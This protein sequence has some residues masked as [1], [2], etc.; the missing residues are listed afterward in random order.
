MSPI[1]KLTVSG[2]R[3][4]L[5]PLELSFRKGG[6]R[7]SIVLYGRNGTGKSSITDAWEWLHASRIQRLAR[8]GAGPTSYPHW[9]AKDDETY[10]EV[11]LSDSDLDVVGLSFDHERPTKPEITGS[12]E[13]FR[14]NAPH[15]CHI[16]FG[17][18]TA[19]VYLTKSERYD[20]LARL[21][22]FTPQVELQKALRRTLRKVEERLTS[23]KE[24]AERLERALADLFGLSE[25]REVHLLEKINRIFSRHNIEKVNDLSEAQA[26]L[27]ALRQKVEVD[28]RARELADLKKLKKAS[29]GAELP[30][31]LWSKIDAFVQ[32]A[33]N[34]N[35]RSGRA[36]SLSFL[37]LYDAAEQLI[38]DKRSRN[39]ATDHCPLCGQKVEEAELLEHVKQELEKLQA[40]K[41]AREQLQTSRDQLQG[42]LTGL[43]DFSLKVKRRC[44]ELELPP[45]LWPIN[46]LGEYAEE[47]DV[48]LKPLTYFISFSD[49]NLTDALLDL[50]PQQKFLAKEANLKLT[51][52]I[53]ELLSQIGDRRADLERDE[54]RSQLVTDYEL[55]QDGVDK[56]G[57]WK[58]SCKEVDRL[59][60]VHDR[61]EAIVDAFVQDSIENVKTQFEDV[62]ADVEKFFEI[63]EE[64]TERIASPALKLLTDQDRAVLLEVEFRGERITPAYRLLSESQLNSFGLAVFLASA[65]N[66]NPG[67]PF[68]IL[69][70][71][72]NSFDAYK[73]PQVIRLLKQEFSSHQ[74][75]IM[76]HDEIWYDRLVEEFPGWI[77]KR[78]VR[79]DATGPVVKPGYSHL[80]QVESRLRNDEPSQAG[81]ILGPYL[82]RQLQE[83]GED[84]QV[85]VTYNQRN[86]YTL[87]DLLVRFRVRV[88]N[89]LG[90]DHELFAAIY[91]LEKERGFRNLCA[92]WKNPASPL[93][94]EEVQLVV[95]AWE[96]IE[97]MVRCPQQSC[98]GFVRYDGSSKKFMCG[99]RQ[100][101]LEKG[102][103]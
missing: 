94:R 56:W 60:E 62:S 69:D 39:V 67:F 76:T 35:N 45:E 66:F 34:L 89:K 50:L 65:K 54:S 99:C 78:F 28:P 93:T 96:R 59:G 29:Q 17:D 26:G 95:D 53:Q 47:V 9:D 63:L 36:M 57:K 1:E 80:E 82:E 14:A 16:R 24:Q 88:K 83:L 71:I 41:R 33:Q 27:V 86:E 87:K 77:R 31:T 73:R 2:F 84:F 21:M 51:E 37:D 48:R 38:E 92:H 7:T 97:K 58:A 42:V 11:Q 79:F 102:P 55:L 75:L 70:D 32:A 46:R 23:K 49:E 13:T 61:F 85:L 20:A 74:C 64:H 8:E 101:V 52:L 91:K 68:L 30:D 100:T 43:D 40:L 6:T 5:T 10:V 103:T 4:I 3:G 25:V 90:T 15:P 72:I 19:F 44:S 12:L 22:G 98:Y 18:L 81:Q